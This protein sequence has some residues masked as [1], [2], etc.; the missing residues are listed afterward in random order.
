MAFCNAGG[1]LPPTIAL[2]NK[3]CQGD[4]WSGEGHINVMS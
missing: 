4:L 2:Q 3:T 1:K